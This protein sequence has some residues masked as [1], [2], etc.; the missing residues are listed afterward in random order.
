MSDI[1]PEILSKLTELIKAAGSGGAPRGAGPSGIELLKSVTEFLNAVAWPAAAVF[2]AL[3]FRQ[4]VTSFLG[5]VETVKVFGAEI[6]RKIDKQIEQSAKE[7]QN[8]SE[9]ELLSGPSEGELER[10]MTVKKLAAN[11]SSGV[12]MAQAESLAADYEHVRASMPPGN[13]RTRAMEVVVSKMRTIGQAFFPLRHEFAGVASPGKRL[14]VIATLQICYDFEMLDWLV[15]RVGS[16]KPFLQYQA[17]VAILLA[18]QGKNAKA[19]IPSL[20]AAVSELGR[21][22]DSFGGDTSRRGTLDEIEK[23]LNDLKR[24][25]QKRA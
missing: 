18:M 8:K 21:F 4:Q 12:V 19:Y 23:V 15:Q 14:M 22:R 5:N 1:S 6:S 7:A 16:E 13:D 11:A 17:L 24:A 25:T 9:A 2:C 3:L 10:A 20:D